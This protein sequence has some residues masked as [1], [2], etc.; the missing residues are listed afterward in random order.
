MLAEISAK[1]CRSRSAALAQP[2]SI[3]FSPEGGPAPPFSILAACSSTMENNYDD[4]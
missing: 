2:E 4:D 1:L 3:D